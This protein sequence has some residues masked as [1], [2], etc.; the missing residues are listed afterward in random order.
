M[1]AHFDLI[2]TADSPTFTAEF[3]LLDGHG[4]Q[5]AYHPADFNN[6][7]ASRLRGLFDLRNYLRTYV[8]PGQESASMAE[9]GVCIA[10]EVLGEDIFNLLWQ[11]QAQ[12][13]L[14]IQLPGA[15]EA[16]NLLAA[17]LSRVPWEI[18]RLAPAQE[19]L[20]DRNLLVRV[21]H[22]RAAPATQAL[23]LAPDESVRVLFVFAEA[24]G[25]RPLAARRERRALLDLFEQKIYPQRRVVVHFLSHGVTRERLEAQIEENGG[26]HIVHWSGHGH[27]NQLEL[28]KPGGERDRISGQDLLQLFADAGGFIPQL[29][30]LSACYS[31]DILRVKDWDDFLAVAQ[32]K[33]PDTKDSDT[34]NSK[35]TS[36]GTKDIAL[37]D[38]QGYTGTAHALLQGGVPTVVA[39]RYAVSD[40]YARELSL[41]FYDALLAH[42]RPKRAA[43]ALTLARRKLQ[44]QIDQGN[45]AR[46]KACDPATPV[47]YGEEQHQVKLPQ[48]RSPGLETRDPRLHRI[49]ELTL[50]AHPYFVGRTWE[51]A[52]LGADFIGASY[53][54]AIKPV[55]VITGLGGMGKTALLAE[56]L[57]L[58]ET[59]FDWVLLYQA[60]PNA[61]TFDTTL[62]DI[63]LKLYGELGRY[64]DHVKAHPADAIY[65]RPDETFTGPDRQA[66]LIRN[67]MRAL[68]DKAI[69]LVIDNF[70][71]N[72]KPRAE[73]GGGDP[74][75]ACQD[76]AWDRCLQALATE[77]TGTRSRVLITCRWPLAALA[78]TPTHQVL[79]GPLTAAEAA[80]Y[81][82]GHDGLSRMFL[83]GDPAEKALAQRLLL[84]SRFHPL[85]MD[86]L[87][88]LATGGPDLRPQLMEALD[89][90]EKNQDASQL[91]NLFAIQPG[92]SKELS[93]LNDALATSL[94]Q[95]I[96]GAG[97]DARRLLWMV[98][99]ANDLVALR[100]LR[101]VW[102]GETPEQ[103]QLRQIK[104]LLENFSELPPELQA[105]LE[106]MPPELRAQ[107]DA[108]PTEPLHPEPTPL[109][110]HL[111][112][113]GL[114]TQ[115]RTGP[116]ETN[117]DLTC[118]ALVRERI[119]AWMQT[120]PQDRGDLTENDIRIAYAD[121]LQGVY[122]NFQYQNMTHALEAGS[123]ALV[124]YVQAKAYNRLGV[125]ASRL[126][127]SMTDPQ[128]L[129]RL[130][131]HL[132][133]AAESAPE[134]KPRWSCLTYLADVL[135]QGGRP[136]ASLT[137]YEQAATQA[138]AAAEAGGVNERQAWLDLGW[139]TGNWAF[140]LVDVG[141]LDSARQRRLESAEVNRK[142]GRS[143]VDV[144]GSELE[145]L[146]I[147]IMQGQAA[148]ALPQVEVHL[149]KIDTWWQAHRAGQ[150]VPQAP[151]LEYLA[152]A[153]IT[154]L[155]I[156]KD[157][158]RAQKDWASAL[159]RSDAILTIEQALERPAEAMAQ[160]RMNRAVALGR[161]H[162]FA[163][164]QTELETC[165]QVF[166]NDR[167]RKARV[168]SSLAGLFNEQ[169]D[170][171]QAIIQERRAL[172]ICEQLPDPGDRA[173][174]HQNLAIYLSRSGNLSMIAESARHRL[175]D[176]IYCLVSGLSQSLQTSF[177]NYVIIFRRARAAG[178]SLTV[179]RVTELLVDPA[180]HPL[181][182]WLKQRQVK[183]D[184]LQAA[185]DQLLDQARQAALAQD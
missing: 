72:L 89:A 58:W 146:R 45:G 19:T 82:R 66:R 71:T 168:L 139:I 21:V 37:D 115:E 108:L 1:P 61:L 149:A 10:A 53:G 87:T 12:R 68:R 57:D 48:G 170:V 26:Y 86:R 112:N 70:E 125:F 90:L 69:L 173:I 65:R 27:L 140:A 75:W 31:G 34:Q 63:H 122:V 159:R 158:D 151:D 131:P 118:H 165:L 153:F 110:R 185:V 36:E 74:V 123:C 160:T 13:T 42:R 143:E 133:K 7:A 94:D 116:E 62:Q 138:R 17:A 2:V 124:Y 29:F 93:Y 172:A 96:L 64:H 39:M 85:L 114:V 161:L 98:A 80:L 50:A 16:D 40:E 8:D 152:R 5:L 105:K 150:S 51:L 6:I 180:F 97:P 18:G 14:R 107:V 162:R 67:L 84:A 76:P 25:A 41:A 175:A 3:R 38:S 129:D 184:E 88:R 59:R 44:V 145:V 134:G 92:D 178:Q 171:A 119:Y 32:G 28:A 54:A 176:L 20:A 147:D 43:A 77:L 23:A 46:Y 47:L 166:Q 95:L 35:N 174:S 15:T 157:A 141:D 9:I 181:A 142:A 121:W 81:L 128:Q 169:G 167:T 177:S 130:L 183:P 144:I 163:E 111:V 148:A 79:L 182:T 91:P 11:S 106:A 73:A 100:L 155:D 127:T 24:R 137:F 179:P 164:A 126:V 99:I 156:A 102:L 4:S 83:G 49:A 30:F 136:D 78:D 135:S 117:P 60:K 101:S 154:A 132:K 109:L 113:V 120:H 52:G 56:A 33:E 55:A 104:Q 22:D 103:L